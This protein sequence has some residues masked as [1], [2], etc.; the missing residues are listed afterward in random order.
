MVK[1]KHNLELT[2]LENETFL[3]ISID[4][5]LLT[6]LFTQTIVARPLSNRLCDSHHIGKGQMYISFSSDNIK[7]TNN[8]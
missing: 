5:L 4:F 7:W 8:G 6:K 2:D 3:N 1:W